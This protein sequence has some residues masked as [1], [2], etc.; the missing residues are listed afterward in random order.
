MTSPDSSSATTLRIAVVDDE[1][2]MRKA[3]WRLLDSHR[4]DVQTVE[5]GEAFLATSPASFDCVVLDLV[6]PAMGG[7]EIA[8]RIGRLAPSVPVVIL[9]GS[10]EE[11]EHAPRAR[12][13][14]VHA[15]LR[16]PV[17]AKLLLAAI[18][19]GIESARRPGA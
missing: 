5:S 19:S 8:R 11:P 17:E 18:Q 13:L 9:T 3:L 12:E 10:I 6:L 15:V 16:K 4:M 14:G 2:G 1:P 7:A